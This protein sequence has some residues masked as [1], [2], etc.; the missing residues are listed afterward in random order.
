MVHLPFLNDESYRKI[1][2]DVDFQP[3]LANMTD[4]LLLINQPLSSLLFLQI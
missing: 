2:V 1:N 4:Y 3:K